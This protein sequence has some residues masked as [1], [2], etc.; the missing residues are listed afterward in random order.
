MAR[1]HRLEQK[2]ILEAPRREVFA[3][4]SDIRNLEIITPPFLNFRNVD[5]ENHEIK[6]GTTIDHEMRLFGIPMKWRSM[7][8]EFQPE[9]R[10]VD[11]QVLGP[12][13]YWHHLHLF[14]DVAGGTEVID[15][16]DYELPMGILGE[17][18]HGLFVRPMLNSIFEYRLE[19][20]RVLFEPVS[21]TSDV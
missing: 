12:Y 18:G 4:F 16:I 7:I 10:F 17:L 13:Q 19:K 9:E 21:S 5:V 3:F 1:R 15:Q 11:S 2:Q 14:R 20:L 6:A 8:E